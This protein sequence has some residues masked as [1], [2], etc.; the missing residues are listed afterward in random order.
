MQKKRL[1]VA[2]KD[3]KKYRG[4]LRKKILRKMK[5]LRK[6]VEKKNLEKSEKIE[7]KS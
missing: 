5:K 6:K 1:F 7:K 3:A 2:I 4:K